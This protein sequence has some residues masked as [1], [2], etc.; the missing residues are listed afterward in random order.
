V[1][2]D[3]APLPVDAECDLEGRLPHTVESAAYFVVAEGLT[4]VVKYSNATRA[5]VSVRR[6]PGGIEVV[7]ADDGVGGARIGG[8]SGLRGL[9]DRVAALE[10]ELVLDSPL[11]GGTRIV[12][13]IPTRGEAVE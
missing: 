5:A 10:G 6:R 11:G 2:V 13:R 12:A 7:V 1:L 8:G 4:N 3:R 9:S